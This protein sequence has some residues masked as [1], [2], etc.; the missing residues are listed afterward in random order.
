M[1][2]ENERTIIWLSLFEKLTL[3][4]ARTLLALYAQPQDI[5]PN[6]VPDKD[7]IQ[8]AVGEELYFKMLAAD[9]TLLD[10]YIEN[11]AKKNIVCITIASKTYPQKLLEIEESPLLLF[12]MGDVSLLQ[13]QAVAI[14]GTRMPT[15]YG[16]EVASKYAEA[17]AK[18]GLIIVSGLASGVDKIAHEKA[19]E[20][21]GKTI[22][23][24]GGG[25]D[26]I[27]PA[28][29]T[30]LAKNIAKNGLLLSEYRPNVN[31]TKYS[32]PFRN[33]I[34]SALCKCVLVAEA[35]EK[36]GALYTKDYAIKQGRDVF[37]PP[38]NITNARGAGNNLMLKNHE[39]FLTT[40]PQDIL[41]WCGVNA[42]PTGQKN[43]CA[44]QL[45]VTEKLIFDALEDKT[46]TFDELQIITG[47][48]AKNLNSC[49]TMLLIRGLIKKLPGN[50]YSL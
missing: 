17:L 8:K 26:C 14:V 22:A 10:S 34:I 44:V 6:L 37:V 23:V 5:L 7:K 3:A 12:A 39:A 40:S 9:R 45:S 28:M 47:L 25:F 20:V 36:S 21:G 11:L 2:N 4:K 19:L 38:C 46:Q 48:N 43:L 18:A 27:Y 50:E 32:F 31:P 15:A 16:R 49:L 13:K 42:V 35:G 33:R 30:N 41:A 1:Y 29:N 24:L